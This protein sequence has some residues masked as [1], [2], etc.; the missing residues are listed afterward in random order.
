MSC[1]SLSSLYLVLSLHILA[2]HMDGTKQKGTARVFNK[3]K[4]NKNLRT[5]E[6]PYQFVLQQRRE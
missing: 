6:I 2:E 3:R 1:Y 5:H 4:L